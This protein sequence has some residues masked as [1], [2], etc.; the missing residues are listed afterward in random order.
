MS[1]EPELHLGEKSDS[2]GIDLN[3][4]E[5]PKS[6]SRPNRVS[7]DLDSNK[8]S[9]VKKTHGSLH[10]PAPAHQKPTGGVTGDDFF[11]MDED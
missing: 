7:A 10:D 11:D 2:T 1:V 8:K 5:N 3:H 4:S 9:K 6:S